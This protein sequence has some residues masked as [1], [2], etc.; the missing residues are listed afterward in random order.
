MWGLMILLG[1]A[2]SGRDL[3]KTGAGGRVFITLWLLVAFIL[4]TIYRVNLTAML[5]V[6][7]VRI[8]FDT[9]EELVNQRKTPWVFSRGS[10]VH[11]TFEAAYKE[12]PNSTM[13]RLWAGK[14]ELI[15]TLSPLTEI[16][17]KGIAGIY[18]RHST[19]H[20]MSL[21]FSQTGRCRL[22]VTRSRFMPVVYS[23]TYPKKS[24]LKP[25]IDNILT[26]LVEFGIVDKFMHIGHENATQCLITS[27]TEQRN[28]LRELAIGDFL[29]I[30]SLYATGMCI[31][32]GMFFLELVYYHTTR[33]TG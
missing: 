11:S 19:V 29:G 20:R 33:T 22:A 28:S 7:K 23:I 12:R 16:A 15:S 6:P 26:S 4:G 32:T 18:V 30:F 13:G 1:Q 2:L 21:D 9:L 25:L 10:V 14:L 24:T 5:V 31:G 27:A 8:P 17:L 3:R